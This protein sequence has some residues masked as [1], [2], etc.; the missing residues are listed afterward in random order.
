MEK[1]PH[2]HTELQKHHSQPPAEAPSAEPGAGGRRRELARSSP[3]PPEPGCPGWLRARNPSLRSPR[4][5]GFGPQAAALEIP[6]KRRLSWGVPAARVLVG[7][8]RWPLQGRAG[9]TT[10]SG[11]HTRP[12]RRRGAARA[13]QVGPGRGREELHM[14]ACAAS[15]LLRG[16]PM[17]F[18]FLWEGKPPRQRLAVGAPRAMHPGTP[19]PRPRHAGAAGSATAE[20][21][22]SHVSLAKSP[23]GQA[24]AHGQ[25]LTLCR[26]RPPARTGAPH[27][28]TGGRAQE[29]AGTL[30]R[31]EASHSPR[32]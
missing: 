15:C 6:G 27:R 22:C 24:P 21:P 8:G 28:V 23:Q 17:P 13:W 19:H 10:D 20:G 2:K 14:L 26:G 7:R 16:E 1:L 5:P 32:L 12:G 4:A 9:A 18:C 29:G 31:E 3:E 30:C 11:G 25:E